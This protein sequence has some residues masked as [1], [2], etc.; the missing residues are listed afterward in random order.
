[1]SEQKAREKIATLFHW[2]QFQI[3][4]QSI[5]IE[6][7]L[8]SIFPPRREKERMKGQKKS[9]TQE[10][11]ELRCRLHVD[12]DG[13]WK[14][15]EVKNINLCRLKKF[16]LYLACLFTRSPS[17]VVHSEMLML[18]LLRRL[19]SHYYCR[20]CCCCSVGLSIFHSIFHS[21]Y[22]SLSLSLSLLLP[23]S[24]NHISLS[25]FAPSFFKSECGK[26]KRLAASGHVHWT[27]DI[28]HA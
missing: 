23:L 25:E 13:K 7:S 19:L 5:S 28:R 27:S 6:K 15:F 12:N 9:W 20:C 11:N 24:W 1:M 18:L 21:F 22:P 8:T 10:M 26:E 2:Q 3:Y 14:L 16:Q 17:I 4:I